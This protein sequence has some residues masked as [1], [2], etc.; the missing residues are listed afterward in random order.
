MKHSNILQTFSL[1]L[2]GLLAASPLAAQ[3]REWTASNGTTKFTAELVNAYDD[4]AYFQK[5]GDGYIHMPITLLSKP[6]VARIVEWARERDSQKAVMM[7]ASQASVTRD[8]CNAWLNR[9]VGDSLT[10]VNLGQLQE[11]NCYAFLM[12]KGAN[13]Y[14]FEMVDALADAEKTI[15]AKDGHFLQL[16]AISPMDGNDLATVIAKLG[17]SGGNWLSSN[18]WNYKSKHE[19]WKGYWRKPEVSVLVLDPQGHALFDSSAKEPDGKNADTLAFM[20]KMTKVAKNIRSGGESVP[21]PYVNHQAVKDILDKALAEKTNSP[22]PKPV[23]IDFSGVDAA[24]FKSMEGND[25]VVSIEIG[26]DGTVSKLVLKKGG[27]PT[28]EQ[29]LRQA[30]TLWQFIPSL[31]DGVPAVKTVMIPLRIKAPA[32]AKAPAQ[33]EA[34]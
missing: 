10:D 19:I 8:I 34:K 16:V 18:E 24:T 17:K 2:F 23:V 30:A 7:G 33:P 1:C 6:D 3:Q 20:N 25:Y 31:K 21:N 4:T 28:I 32:P 12:V 14:F 26:I 13:P 11:P 5:M 27:D 29:A 22:H 9:V 15:N